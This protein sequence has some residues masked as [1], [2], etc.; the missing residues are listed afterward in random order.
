MKWPRG[1]SLVAADNSMPMVRAV[2]PGNIP[3]SRAVVCANWPSLPLRESSCDLVAGDGSF[4][5][6][7]Y[8]SGF[9]ALAAEI[10][11]VLRDD[12]MLI[13]RAYIQPRRPERA[14]DLVADLLRGAIP[15]FHWFKFRLLMA[16]QE[17]TERGV[18]VEEVYRYWASQNIDEAALIAQTGWDAAG[19]RMIELYRGTDTVHTF[20]TLAELREVLLEFFEEV[21]IS[22]PSPVMADRCPIL[23]ARLRGNPR[24]SRRV[25]GVA[26]CAV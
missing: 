25:S 15:S 22:T 13:L 12:G 26:E 10:R 8:P 16:L 11:R 9:Q 1:A 14:E 24:R 19:I 3:R 20:S 21:A 17:S 6:L 23:M 7:R 18:P 4:S 2:W 5:C